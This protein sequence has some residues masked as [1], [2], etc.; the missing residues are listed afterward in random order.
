VLIV[1]I[2]HVVRNAY[3][4]VLQLVGMEQQDVSVSIAAD[5]SGLQCESKK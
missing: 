2:D 5:V 1:S 3:I 4:S